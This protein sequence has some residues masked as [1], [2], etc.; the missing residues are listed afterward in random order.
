MTIESSK[1]EELENENRRNLESS[2]FVKK[3]FSTCT[4]LRFIE[5]KRFCGWVSLATHLVEED[6]RTIEHLANTVVVADAKDI[7]IG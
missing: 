3:T 2:S 4:L 6:E 5:M 1:R 7:C